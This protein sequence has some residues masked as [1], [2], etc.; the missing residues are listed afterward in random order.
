MK[1]RLGNECDADAEFGCTKAL[2]KADNGVSFVGTI[3]AQ[4]YNPRSEFSGSKL[5]ILKA[6]VEAKGLDFLNGGS[7]SIGKRYYHRPDIHM[8][9]LQYISLTG[10]GAGFDGIKAGPGKFSYAFFKDNDLSTRDPLTG[11][12]VDTTA[13]RRNNLL[14]T[15]MPVNLNGTLDVVATII[16]AEGEGK[17]SG[18]QFSLFWCKR[19]HQT[20]GASRPGLPL[21]RGPSMRSRGTSSWRSKWEATAS[22]RLPKARRHG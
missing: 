11:A 16:S 12:V 4:A 21:A 9:D 14:Y 19:T 8:L 10:T 15:D 20:R 6:Y 22:A 3:R 18:W 1:Y 13:A 17:H 2:L 5:D 7:A